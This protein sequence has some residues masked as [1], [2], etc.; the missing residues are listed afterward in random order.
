[1]KRK[2]SKKSLRGSRTRKVRKTKIKN[3]SK[4]IRKTR[5][6]NKNQKK[7]KS[8]K[9]KKMFGGMMKDPKKQKIEEEKIIQDII[10]STNK[11]LSD[12][13]RNEIDSIRQFHLT[14]NEG[15]DQKE[16]RMYI[17]KIM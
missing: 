1:M 15:Q 12:Q 5:R 14:L 3:S 7:K 6:L 9:T 4:R 11:N 13:D 2:Q 17:R 10:H 8:R 16:R